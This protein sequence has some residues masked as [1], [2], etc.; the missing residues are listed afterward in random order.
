[1]ENNSI[2]INSR[3]KSI[4]NT[5]II[6]YKAHEKKMEAYRKYL[7]STKYSHLLLRISSRGKFK[8][9]RPVQ[10]KLPYKYVLC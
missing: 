3:G 1:M 7:S 10:N 8:R 9:L 4:K 5:G 6:N 2:I